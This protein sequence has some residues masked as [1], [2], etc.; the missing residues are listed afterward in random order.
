MEWY[1][2]LLIVLGYIAL[3]IVTSI[4]FARDKGFSIEDG[5]FIGLFWPVSP[6]IQAPA[7]FFGGP[8]T[9]PQMDCIN[10]PRKGGGVWVTNSN[11][12]KEEK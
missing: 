8:C 1:W 7:C 4:L 5:V 12:N 6:N 3:W 9:N 10:C 2:I 11:L